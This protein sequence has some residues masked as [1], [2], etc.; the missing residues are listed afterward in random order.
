MR[1]LRGGV[2]SVELLPRQDW[3]SR[4]AAINEGLTAGLEPARSLPS[5]ADVRGRRD[6]RDRD[7]PAGGPPVRHP[8]GL[9]PRGGCVRSGNLIYAMPPFICTPAEIEQITAAMVA[10]ARALG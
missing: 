2:A 8:G 4:V 3:K 1:W 9:G 10:V 6:R 5:V 7:T